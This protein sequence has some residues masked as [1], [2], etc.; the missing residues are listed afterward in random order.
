M[1]ADVPGDPAP[2]LP[3][4]APFRRGYVKVERQR[5][6]MFCR[7]Y[8]SIEGTGWIIK[9]AEGVTLTKRGAIR[10]GKRCINRL[11]RRHR[12]HDTEIHYV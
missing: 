4:P 1:F 10:A 3:R 5:G 12:R 8:W 9:N 7:Y 11:E 6:F 2:P